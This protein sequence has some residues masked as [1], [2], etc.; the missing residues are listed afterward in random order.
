[1]TPTSHTIPADNFDAES[2]HAAE[3]SGKPKTL[4]FTAATFIP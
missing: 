3:F 2:A 4:L 1:M